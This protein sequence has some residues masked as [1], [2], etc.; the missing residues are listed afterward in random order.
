MLA[1]THHTGRLFSPPDTSVQDETVSVAQCMKWGCSCHSRECL[2]C[3]EAAQY[4]L[5]RL[6]CEE[7][8]TLKAPD[9]QDRAR[10]APPASLADLGLTRCRLPRLWGGSACRGESCMWKGGQNPGLCVQ[11]TCSQRLDEATDSKSNTDS[12]GVRLVR[13]RHCIH[14]LSRA[15][16]TTFLV[17]IIYIL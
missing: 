17:I 9:P 6:I 13:S 4:F 15:V 7:F 1:E 3:F 11:K 16:F 8:R 5:N 10:N 12:S 2:S 14:L